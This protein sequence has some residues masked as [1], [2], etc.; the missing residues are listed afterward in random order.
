MINTRVDVCSNSG[1]SFDKNKE[2]D[3]IRMEEEV[4]DFDIIMESSKI[5]EN[6]K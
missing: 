2:L 6:N 1:F 3:E 4:Q 5:S